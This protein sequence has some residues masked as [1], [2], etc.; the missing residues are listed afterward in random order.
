[1]L[2]NVKL[3]TAIG[4]SVHAS[5]MKMDYLRMAALAGQMSHDVILG[6]NREW[7]PNL[8]DDLNRHDKGDPTRTLNQLEK[9][10]NDMRNSSPVTSDTKSAPNLTASPD[11]KS[12]DDILTPADVAA[13]D[14]NGLLA[15][16]KPGDKLPD[17]LLGNENRKDNDKNSDDVLLG[18]PD[19]SGKVN[20]R[21]D[22]VQTNAPASRPDRFD[23]EVWAESGG[24]YRQDFA[25]RYRPS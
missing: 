23:P 20:T 18:N 10:L 17:A 9:P 19:R 5:G 4:E 12:S 14:K 13:D 8:R 15:P 3:V 25:I 22:N 11:A 24:W 1:R 21:S 2:E 7:F 6:A 16:D